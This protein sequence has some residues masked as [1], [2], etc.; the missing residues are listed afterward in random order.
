MKHECI[1]LDWDKD[2]PSL[3]E[4]LADIGKRVMGGTIV[5]LKN[6]FRPEEMD[7]CKKAI[8]DWWQDVEKCNPDH[9]TMGKSWWRRVENSPSITPHLSWVLG[10]CFYVIDFTVNAAG[11]IMNPDV[12]HK[13]IRG[14][15]MGTRYRGQLEGVTKESWDFVYENAQAEGISAYQ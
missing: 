10:N 2:S 1:E 3:A 14:G 15:S 13:G 5:I 11:S 7:A 9:I 4:D 8:L 12:P 6:I